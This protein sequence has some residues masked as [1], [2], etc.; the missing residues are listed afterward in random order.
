MGSKSC[1]ATVLSRGSKPAKYP[2]FR[3][4]FYSV[5]IKLLSRQVE[6]SSGKCVCCCN[7]RWSID[8]SFP[9]VQHAGRY[10]ARD[11]PGCQARNT[12][13]SHRAESWLQ[14]K[15][16]P[17]TAGLCAAD[18]PACFSTWLICAWHHCVSLPPW[19]SLVCT[20]GHGMLLLPLNPCR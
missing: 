18:L 2:S 3:Q 9:S 10:R 14:M 20:Q 4:G 5:S 16:S 8:N 19:L 12:T 15:V 6:A 13:V 17:A 1:Q 7:G 11:V